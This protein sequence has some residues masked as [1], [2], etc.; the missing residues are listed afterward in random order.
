[1]RKG[2]FITTSYFTKEA[3]EYASMIESKIILIDGEQLA[4]LMAEHNVGVST[5]GQY[6]VKKLDSD[7]FDEE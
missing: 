3:N 4:K 1:A 7:Y 6:E 2:V 5:V